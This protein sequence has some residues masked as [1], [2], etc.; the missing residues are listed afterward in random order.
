MEKGGF[1]MP[2]TARVIVYPDSL[3]KKETESNQERDLF[4]TLSESNNQERLEQRQK[5]CLAEINILRSENNWQGILDLF[6][7]LEEKEPELIEMQMDVP[8]RREIAFAL[9]Q[10]NKFEEAI[11]QFELCLQIDK[12]N[13]YYHAGLAFTLYDCLFACKNKELILPYPK[14][15]SFIEKAHYHFRRAQELRKDGVTNY[16][17]EGMLFKNIQ[18]KPKQA[19]PL[20]AQ[21]VKNWENYSQEQKRARHQEYKNYIKSLYNLASCQLKNDQPHDALANIQKCIELDQDKNY[22]KN[23]HKY[24]ALGKIHYQLKNFSQAQKALEFACTFTT[25]IEGDYILELLA[26]V[27]LAQGKP[28]QALAQVRKLPAQ[29]KRPFV[30]WAEADVL[31]ALGRLDEAKKILLRSIEKDRRSKH[32]GLI[33]LVKIAFRQQ[34]YLQ[35]INYAKQANDFHLK[36]YTTPDPDSLFW[37]G[38]AYL[39]LNQLEKAGQVIKELADFRPNYGLLPKLKTIYQQQKDKNDASSKIHI[40]KNS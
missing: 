33:R 13:F 20:F 21:A 34:N 12:N 14:K 18:D 9:G 24:F 11:E 32:K 16:Y 39:R 17:R 22:F 36:T 7:P 23:E 8:I 40:L 26:R 28:E 37:L 35:A 15:K 6:Y 25:P 31:A 4:L 1:I 27:F 19:L 10:L 3:A 38:G 29:R 30:C 2:N 5:R